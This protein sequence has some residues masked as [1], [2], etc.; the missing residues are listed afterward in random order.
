MEE[1]IIQDWTPYQ[2]IE[3]ESQTDD[4]ARQ[5]MADML[6]HLDG[7][8]ALDLEAFAETRTLPAKLFELWPAALECYDRYMDYIIATEGWQISCRRGCSACCEH[9]LARG[10]TALEA[11]TI[12]CYVRGWGDIETVYETS[13]QNMLAFQ[14]LLAAEMRADPR[15]LAPDDARVTRAHL[16]YNRLQRPC[17]FLDKEKGACRIYPVRPMVCR[18]FFNLSAAEWCAPDHA[19]YLKRETRCIDPYQAV[20]ERL[21]AINQRLGVRALNFLAGAFVAIAGEVMEGR[22]LKLT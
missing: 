14:R 2:Q 12:Y 21:K 4:T 3:V 18:Y 11:L 22:P 10:V 6:G 19:S 9:E 17:A 16:Q 5:C 1:Q 7:I 15:P 8:L 13:G 20:K